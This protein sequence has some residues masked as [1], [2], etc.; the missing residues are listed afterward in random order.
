MI[1]GGGVPILAIFPSRNHIPWKDQNDQEKDTLVRVQ[2]KRRKQ[3]PVG[4]PSRLHFLTKRKQGGGGLLCKSRPQ[5]AD[6]GHLGRATTAGEKELGQ[7]KNLYSWKMCISTLKPTCR[8]RLNVHSNLGFNQSSLTCYPQT[9]KPL[10]TV[11]FTQQ[12]YKTQIISAR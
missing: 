7:M 3:Q 4:N 2:P 12:S 1:S 10:I 5:N 9:N 8:K 6:W 11:N